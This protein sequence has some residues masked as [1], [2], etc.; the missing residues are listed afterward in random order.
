MRSLYSFGRV[1]V[2]GF[3]SNGVPARPWALLQ[4]QQIPSLPW[5]PRSR[6]SPCVLTAPLGL[7]QQVVIRAV[8]VHLLH[9]LLVR[10]QVFHLVI[11]GQVGRGEPPDGVFGVALQ[12][13]VLRRGRVAVGEGGL[14]AVLVVLVPAGPGADDPL[15]EV[16]HGKE[17]QQDQD[18][19]QLPRD[20]ADVVKEHVDGELAAVLH[21]AAAG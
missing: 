12:Q 5:G 7:R 15:D 16:S 11:G 1:S 10:G 2:I 13:G 6:G 18:A 3:P 4:S 19:R 21:G 9:A 14:L 20:P 8:P 17:Q